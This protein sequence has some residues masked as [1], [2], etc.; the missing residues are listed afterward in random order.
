M[1][2]VL[3]GASESNVEATAHRSTLHAQQFLTSEA[4]VPSESTSSEY[5]SPAEVH[6][7]RTH[8]NS[9]PNIF[10]GA[11]FMILIIFPCPG[12]RSI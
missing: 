3:H 7:A 10:A 9:H 11:I 1:G 5:L 8:F 2:N 6:P 12:L 4:S